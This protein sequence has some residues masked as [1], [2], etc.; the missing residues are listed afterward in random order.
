MSRI[1]AL[2]ELRQ[3][4]FSEYYERTKTRELTQADAAGLLGMS[5]RTFRR[6]GKHLEADGAEGLFDRRLSKVA[7]NRVATDTV[8]GM[9]NPK[10]GS[11]LRRLAAIWIGSQVKVVASSR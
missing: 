1:E 10:N 3:M 8:M 6:Y 5:E 9:L 7:G 11:W 2:Q 4:K